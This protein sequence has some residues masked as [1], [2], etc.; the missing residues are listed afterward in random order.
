[1]PY[2]Y[3][4]MASMLATAS[5][6]VFTGNPEGEFFALDAKSGNKLW[7]YQTGAGNRGAAV[8]YAVN[9]RQFIATGTGWQA[10]VAGG[11]GRVLFPEVEW[12]LGSTLVVF[13]LPEGS[14]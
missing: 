1:M 11:M 3:I 4:L 10:S 2:K 5:D 14:R 6:L 7:S 8:S 13:A 9:G 12:R